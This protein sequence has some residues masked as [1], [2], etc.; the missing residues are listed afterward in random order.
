MNKPKLITSMYGD[1]NKG[2]EEL[3][4]TLQADGAQSTEASSEEEEAEE[5]ANSQAAAKLASDDQPW[6]DDDWA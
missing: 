2:W 6:E 4:E 5:A 3:G 1:L